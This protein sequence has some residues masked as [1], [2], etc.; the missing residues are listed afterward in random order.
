[1][2]NFTQ[3]VTMAL[4]SGAAQVNGQSVRT[5]GNPVELQIVQAPAALLAL[6][7]STDN[8]NWAA[9]SDVAAAAITTVG[10]GIYVVRERGEFFRLIVAID[11]AAP[12]LYRAIL[13]IHKE[14]G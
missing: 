6:Q 9:A 5:G 4:T 1:M 11:G 13:I 12:Q 3:R 2:A 14:G 10:A 8:V 7:V